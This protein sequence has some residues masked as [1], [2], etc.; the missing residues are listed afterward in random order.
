MQEI[1]EYAEWNAALWNYFFKNRD[2]NPILCIDDNM[3][4]NIGESA[5]IEIEND[6]YTNDF[7]KKT[8]LDTER[9]GVFST[10]WRE[11]T[12]RPIIYV[13]NK[14]YRRDINLW[15][16][17]D[18]ACFLRSE[19]IDGMPAYFGVL[20]AIMYIAC[21]CQ[22]NIT[23]REIK[24]GATPFL[25]EGYNSPLGE[26]VDGML[27]QLHRD[28]PSFDAD[29]IIC[30]NQRNM[31][32][33]KFHAIFKPSVRAG[34]INFLEANNLKWES[35]Y[36]PYSDYV[37]YTLIPALNNGGKRDYISYVIKQE[38]APY[39][40]N[41]LTSGLNFGRVKEEQDVT[42]N[43]DL[44]WKYELYFD[45]EGT[46][47]FYISSMTYFPFGVG[48]A[49]LNFIEDPSNYGNEYLA[50]EV[51]F[52]VIRDSVIYHEGKQFTL[53]NLCNG[54]WENLYFVKDTEEAYHQVSDLLDGNSYLWF[55]RNGRGPRV[56]NNIWHIA[57]IP[58]NV[59]GYQIYETES[60]V[61]PRQRRQSA[62]YKD[63]FNLMVVGSWACI[64]LQEG[65]RLFWKPDMYDEDDIE[66]IPSFN[67]DDKNFFRLPISD[68]NFS[69][70]LIVSNVTLSNYLFH[71]SIVGNISW[72]G[73]SNRYFINGWGEV[74]TDE[75]EHSTT[76]HQLR[77]QLIQNGIH[78][79]TRKANILIQVLY[80]IADANGCVG[81]RKLI[82]A[83]NFV[84]GAFGIEPTKD[85][86]R[87]IIYALKRLGYIT[88]FKTQDSREYV[89]QLNRS[90]LER[91]NYGI[92][93]TNA[94]LV[95]GVYSQCQ[96]D[97]LLE[98][99]QSDFIIYRRPYEES[100]LLRYPEYAVLPDMILVE[101]N[102]IEQFQWEVMDHPVGND[103]LDIMSNINCYEDHFIYGEGDLLMGT[104]YPTPCTIKDK[105]GDEVLCTSRENR[106]YLHKRYL[107]DDIM[108]L[109]PKH[110][111]RAF[112]Q[113][114]HNSPV[115]IMEVDRVGNVNY[116]KI[117][118]ASGMARPQVFDMAF[119]DLN[120]GLPLTE[121][122]FFVDEM[123]G[124]LSNRLFV[125]AKTYST[126]ATRVNHAIFQSALEKI[127]GREITDFRNSSPVY[128]CQNRGQINDYRMQRYKDENRRVYLILER[129]N[130]DN[131][132]ETIAVV[133]LGQD[134]VIA[135][136]EEDGCFYE[137][138]GRS[139]E[140]L[141][142]I[143]CNG[144]GMLTF[145]GDAQEIIELDRERLIEVRIIKNIQQ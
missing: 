4:R 25:G 36:Q 8:F 47:S 98:G 122:L 111:S 70:K 125:E 63:A 139:K 97:D 6:D 82:A 92:S 42:S 131:S 86:K 117:T 49:D 115:C 80:D 130:R 62:R 76:N 110:L 121:Y 119:C 24:N 52:Q 112:C 54:G 114:E 102:N 89:N 141:S 105:Y 109:I 51:C 136:S 126:H 95:K 14:G 16:F 21:N 50:A 84:L 87:S 78:T 65:Q 67:V 2:E 113:M 59:D 48:L 83:L 55:R 138:E 96:I 88:S 17:K 106:Y 32:R 46:S 9:I 124:L 134:T 3:L 1:N 143:I 118:F 5:H 142:S 15:D 60:Y 145:G 108:E 26:L 57:K 128:L 69:G 91:S 127:S 123:P 77:M 99:I 53:K 12:G 64:N 103:L 133:S 7:L 31:S 137:V 33:I 44:Y 129:L 56:D 116:S 39:I 71:E 37:N 72:D 100:D 29:R 35:G 68:R 73:N 90:Y 135:K 10:H 61:R 23:H 58:L 85:N 120:L 43:I 30:G 13:H 34:F 104:K 22:N 81:E 11:R 94:Y 20:C 101:A 18:L 75:P 79:P 19:K 107:K 45:Y 38:N 41:L 140:I 66:I 93:N 144:T 132:F 28:V 74:T 27:F 40:K